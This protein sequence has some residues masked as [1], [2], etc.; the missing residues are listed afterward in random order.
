MSF[1]LHNLLTNPST[2]LRCYAEVDDV[3]G[4]NALELS[5]LRNLKYIEAALRETLRFMS[6]IVVNSRHAK[7]ETV[8]GGKYKI[9]PDQTLNLNLLAV[10][11]D[12][13]VW[14]DDADEFRPERFLNGGWDKLPAHAW[15]PFGTGVRACIGRAFAE[16]EMLIAAALIFQRFNIEMA[17]PDYQFRVKSTLTIKPEGF[18]IKVQRRPGKPDMLGIPGAPAERIPK[19]RAKAATNERNASSASA[20]LAIFYGGN[21]GTCKAFAEDVLSSAR[22]FGFEGTI[23]SLD[24]ATEA[25][26]KDQVAIVVTAT[27]E[28][29][30]PD[31]AK[32]FVAWLQHNHG[33]TKLLEGVRYAIFG[34][35]NS[36]WT[37]TYHRIPRLIDE[38]MASLSAERIVSTAF[39]DV[40]ED[41]VGPFETWKEALFPKLPDA[42]GGHGVLHKQQIQVDLATPPIYEVLAGHEPSE[43]IIIVN[44]QLAA[45]FEDV[46]RKMHMEVRLPMGIEYQTGMSY[47]V[48]S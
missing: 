19:E 43:A 46:P 16:Q 35:G 14:G 6:P 5:H 31:N 10:H 9:R 44:R 21:S 32:Q 18:S 2:L 48:S 28:G 33:Q 36:G 34:V 30:P 8:I 1:L 37:S 13:E 4:N 22:D 17:D 7:E 41:L 29:Q 27:Y 24:A 11:H 40:N 15:K 3:V 39:V 25:L 42:A 12:R 26:T 47:H 23:R 38:T 45:K 20:P